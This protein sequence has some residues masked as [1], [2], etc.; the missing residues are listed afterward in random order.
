M[1]LRKLTIFAAPLLLLQG[2]ATLPAQTAPDAR[3]LVSAADPRAAEAGREMLREGGSAVD[4][5]LA[6]GLRTVDV[7]AAGGP[8]ATTSQIGDA[9]LTALDRL[10]EKAP[11]D[12]ERA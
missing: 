12:L 1:L 9:I 5:A 6:T 8:H 11:Q 7:A 4:A 3:G 2:C 10:Q